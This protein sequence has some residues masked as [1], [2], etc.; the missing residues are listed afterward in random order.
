MIRIDGL[1]RIEAILKYVVLACL[2]VWTVSLVVGTPKAQYLRLFASADLSRVW[3]AA[4]DVL[5]GK[6]LLMLAFWG[7]FYW[8]FFASHHEDNA[9]PGTTTNRRD[10]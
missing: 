10:A 7:G 6:W 3:Q 4:V 1:Q 5:G 8:I 9:G 2:C